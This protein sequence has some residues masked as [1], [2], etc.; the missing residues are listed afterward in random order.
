MQAFY[1]VFG[2]DDDV[3]LSYYF[4]HR[5]DD[6]D[7]VRAQALD[8]MEDTDEVRARETCLTNPLQ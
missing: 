7:D 5:D 6:D 1:T 3:L 8:A 4:D 2:T